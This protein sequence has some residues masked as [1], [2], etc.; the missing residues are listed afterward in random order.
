MSIHKPQTLSAKLPAM[1][2]L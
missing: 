1:V 2:V